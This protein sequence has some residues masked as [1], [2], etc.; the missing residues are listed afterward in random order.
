MV[1]IP[2]L[3]LGGRMCR[4]NVNKGLDWAGG[5]GEGIG[6]SDS[7]LRRAIW[8]GAGLCLNV[9]YENLI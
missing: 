7:G 3:L 6:T 2:L 9:S 1:L 5:M 4:E 8:Y